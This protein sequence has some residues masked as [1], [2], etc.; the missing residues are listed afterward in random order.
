[1]GEAGLPQGTPVPKGGTAEVATLCRAFARMVG[2]LREA[3]EERA[4]TARQMASAERL[5]ALGEVAAGLAHEIN[6]PLD[7]VMACVRHLEADP[8]KGERARRFL[9]MIREGTTRIERVIR[10]I[11]V[12]AS[13][14]A[15]VK[16][17]PC[18][19]AQLV[20]GTAG[21]VEARMNKRGIVFQVQV[22]KGCLCLGEAQTLSQVLLNLLL[23]AADAAACRKAGAAIIRVGSTC[24]NGVVRICVE[25]SGP[26]VRPERAEEIFQPF[27]TTKEPGR[28]TGL[29]LTVS[30][31]SV[32]AMGG[33]L[34]LAPRPSPLGGACF[35]ITLARASH[36]K[37]SG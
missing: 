18:H 22:R 33:E 8:E 28:G 30:R 4:S 32:R 12:F 23:N 3:E 34:S 9:P 29:G 6:N 37:C 35:V 36:E 5:A 15:K 7:G 13:P 17:A 26:G 2:E 25:D 1:V 20:K 19:V 31:Q 24:E 16:V 21:L 11:L 14:P 10:Q 27:F